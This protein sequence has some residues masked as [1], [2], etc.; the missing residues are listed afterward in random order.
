[1][2]P[3]GRASIVA[4]SPQDFAVMEGG[5][6]NTLGAKVTCSFG[7]DENRGRNMSDD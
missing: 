4:D 1:M 3:A 5:E 2:T 6:K 7:V